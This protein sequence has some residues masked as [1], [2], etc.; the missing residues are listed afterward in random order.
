M[1]YRVV[2]LRRSETSPSHGKTLQNMLYKNICSFK[3][4]FVLKV[5]LHFMFLIV[6]SKGAICTN[7]WVEF[8]KCNIL[9]F[10]THGPPCDRLV[11]DLREKL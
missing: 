11:Y 3:S 2:K 1:N 6:R 8:R 7:F 10:R 4:G 9:Q 5:T